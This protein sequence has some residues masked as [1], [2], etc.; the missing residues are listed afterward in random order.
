M[1]HMVPATA[2]NPLGRASMHAP[3]PE[4]LSRAS[5]VRTSSKKSG[6]SQ[7]YNLPACMSPNMSTL[8]PHKTPSRILQHVRFHVKQVM[9]IAVRH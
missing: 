4:Q 9:I 3:T 8:K 5:V 7:C 2:A 6:H 1:S